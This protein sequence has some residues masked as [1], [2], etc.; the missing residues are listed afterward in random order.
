MQDGHEMRV[1]SN[2][3]SSQG[4]RSMSY[5]PKHSRQGDHEKELENL[6]KQVNDL[7]IEL[8]GQHWRREQDNSSFN[9]NYI[10]GASS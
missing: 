3:G 7:E 9:P 1:D 10:P 2:E 5:I 8:R 6:W 4:E